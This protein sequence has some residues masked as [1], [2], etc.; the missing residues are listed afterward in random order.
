M[1]CPIEE[2]YRRRS[3]NRIFMGVQ[4]GDIL[5]RI[6]SQIS[7][8]FHLFQYNITELEYPFREGT[9]AE[10]INLDA[11]LFAYYN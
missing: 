7:V 9:K 4:S 1:Q 2:S 5:S 11:R 10:L 6:I 3:L 8:N